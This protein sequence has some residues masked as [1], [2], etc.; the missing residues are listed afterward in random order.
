MLVHNNNNP[1]TNALTKCKEIVQATSRRADG[2]VF[3][4]RLLKAEDGSELRVLDTDQGGQEV[5]GL[6]KQLYW[7]EAYTELWKRLQK[8]DV[9]SISAFVRD[10]EGNTAMLATFDGNPKLVE[11]WMII[12]KANLSTLLFVVFICSSLP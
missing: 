6:V 3:E 8:L 1:I 12:K 7:L 4:T 5:L 2:D 11:S 10:F 9:E